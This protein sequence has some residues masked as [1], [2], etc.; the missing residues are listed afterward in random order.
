MATAQIS[1]KSKTL[2]VD[3]RTYG[4]AGGHLRPTLLGRLGG[5]DLIKTEYALKVIRRQ[6]G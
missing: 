2:F 1:W 4:R 5:V 3:R 6:I